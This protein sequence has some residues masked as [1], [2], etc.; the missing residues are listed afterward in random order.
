MSFSPPVTDQE[1]IR[2]CAGG[3]EPALR[4]LFDRYQGMVYN[5]LFRMLGSRDDADEL[6]PE[7]FLKV[8]NGARRF[9]SRANPSTW[10]HRIAAN[11]CI[12]RLRRRPAAPSL[13]LEELADREELAAV[14]YDP[15]LSLVREQE[16]VQ[17]QTGLMALPPED[18]LLITLYH[19]QERSYEEV[20]EITGLSYAL[21]K[22]RLFRARQRLREQYRKLEEEATD[23][24]MP[25][26]ST[27]T[28]RFQ[29]RPA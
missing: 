7:V 11:T 17:L 2:R 25:E 4:L 19:L 26:G 1:L 5:L 3:D 27:P 18:R 24:E 13:S 6:V 28:A 10:I 8:W 15:T 22:S 20:R 14:P 16:R 29:L 9:Q 21:L 12:D 23:D